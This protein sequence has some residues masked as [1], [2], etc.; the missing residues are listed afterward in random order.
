MVFII[1]AHLGNQVICLPVITT[2]TIGFNKFLQRHTDH[3]TALCA[4]TEMYTYPLLSQN[5]KHFAM[6]FGLDQ[7]MLGPGHSTQLSQ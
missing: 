1:A 7:L 3:L 5:K 6:Y 2:D 4:E